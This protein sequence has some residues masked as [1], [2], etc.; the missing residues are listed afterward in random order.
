MKRF[1]KLAGIIIFAIVAFIVIASLALCF[2][3]LVFF[4]FWVIP[5]TIYFF[6]WTKVLL[7]VNREK[8]KTLRALRKIKSRLLGLDFR[9]RANTVD[10]SHEDNCPSWV[11]DL[12]KLRD[13]LLP[14]LKGIEEKIKE[15][16]IPAWR[17]DKT[18][19]LATK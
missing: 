3:A 14:S 6:I 17:V 13:D 18:L 19:W 2:V 8:R 7:G 11:D 12:V 9:I 15:L 10:L 5:K 1:F 4:F 16:K